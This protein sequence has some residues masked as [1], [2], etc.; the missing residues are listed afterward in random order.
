MA[1]ENVP[2]A[3]VRQLQE[4]RSRLS[5]EVRFRCKLRSAAST[6][7]FW[8]N[9]AGLGNRETAAAASG[10]MLTSVRSVKVEKLNASL[11]VV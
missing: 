6:S 9:D 4:T 8:S 2:S 3:L 11:D 1:A 5:T 10:T 7:S